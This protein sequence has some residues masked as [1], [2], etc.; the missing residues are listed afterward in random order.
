MTSTNL[1]T[2]T[3]SSPQLLGP[4]SPSENKSILEHSNLRRA[5]GDAILTERDLNVYQSMDHSTALNQAKT[6]VSSHKS[7][8]PL[9]QISEKAES[10]ADLLTARDYD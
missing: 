7:L 10:W 1:K 4:T 3:L 5:F 8:T 2:R 6:Y 9:V